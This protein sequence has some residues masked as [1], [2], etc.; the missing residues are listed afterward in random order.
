MAAV[1][2]LAF[3]LMVGVLAASA[4]GLIDLVLP[5]HPSVFSKGRQLHDTGTARGVW[6]RSEL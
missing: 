5:E 3:I 4:S 6:L 2:R 1:N